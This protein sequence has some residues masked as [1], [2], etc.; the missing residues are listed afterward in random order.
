MN[1]KNWKK[2]DKIVATCQIKK[3]HLKANKTHYN[4]QWV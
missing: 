1:V 2:Y 4:M 3:V